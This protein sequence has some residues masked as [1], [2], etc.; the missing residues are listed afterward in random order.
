MKVKMKASLRR[1][2]A[3]GL[4][5]LLKQTKAAARENGKAYLST[6]EANQ[7][8]ARIEW[9]QE[10]LPVSDDAEKTWE[11]EPHIITVYKNAF[12][13][14]GVELTKT[15]KREKKY[16]NDDAAKATAE[17]IED[18]EAQLSELGE[19]Y[20]FLAALEEEEEDEGDPR[21]LT[22]IGAGSGKE[23]E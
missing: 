16:E 13:M 14:V 8:I 3:Q 11:V 21:Q 12:I 19:R 9:S 22:F 10:N 5:L 2:L 23:D 4:D 1:L 18:V 7:E 6:T 17:Q 15:L 20:D